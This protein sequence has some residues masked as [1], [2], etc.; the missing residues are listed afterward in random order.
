MAAN[1]KTKADIQKELNK[2]KSEL[3]E[4]KQKVRDKALSMQEE[5]GY[6]D[7]GLNDFLETVGLELPR[8]TV[9]ICTSFRISFTDD[10]EGR[11]VI[12]N[13]DIRDAIEKA[14]ENLVKNSGGVA[15]A[16]KLQK[17]SGYPNYTYEETGETGFSVEV[18]DRFQD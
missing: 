6:C 4:F 15:S 10:N 1:V 2:T 7:G 16:P 8:N 17:Y 12:S 9:Q 13:E 11:D 5:Y 14:L 18:D 3:E